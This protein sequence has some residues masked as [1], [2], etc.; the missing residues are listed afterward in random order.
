M[1][2][3]L[4]KFQIQ[5]NKPPADVFNFLCNKDS[6]KQQSGSPVLLL[7]KTTPGPL[8]VGTR[9][10]EIVQMMPFIKGE[11]LSEVTR[12]E[13]HN[14]LEEEWVGGGMKGILTYF[15]NPVGEGTELIQHVNIKALGLLKPFDAMISRTYTKAAQYRL[16]CLKAVLETGQ[17]P[18]LQ[19]LKWWH[20][21]RKPR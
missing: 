5:I 14:V 4:V 6:Y 15:F 12:F 2:R 11:I 19:K 1:N 18:D 13:P 10:R 20:L 3:M 17:C 8:G 7:E 16:D 21:K 9:Y